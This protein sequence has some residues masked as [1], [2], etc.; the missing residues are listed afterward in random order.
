MIQKINYV[1][2]RVFDI[3]L[4]PFGFINPFWGVLFLSILMA[5]VVL[6]IYKKI[7]SP[8]TIKITKEKIKANILAIRIYKDFWRVILSSFFKSLYYTGKYFSL[9]LVPLLVIIPIL[10]PVFV[11]MD[12]RYGMRPFRVGEEIV[13]KAWVAQ[14]PI[15]LE[16]QL[17]ENGNIKTKMNPVFINGFSDEKK[18]QPIK[19][20]DWKIEAVRAGISNIQVKINTRAYEKSLIIGNYSGALS[21]RK[22]S[23]STWGHF[24]YPVEGLF[25]ETGVVED[26]Y[27]EYPGAVISF[28]GLKMHWLI[29]N[30]VLVVI[31][32][33]AFRKRFGIEF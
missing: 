8:K 5:F 14:D 9:N 17:L 28:A 15:G 1:I 29:Y 18:Q 22:Y 25:G 12:V 30:I 33:L 26:I 20:I 3:I 19:E 16:A 27:I 31:I 24:L 10:F 23:E 6:M 32:A 13:I 21:N 11:Q 7:S 2:T 4:Y